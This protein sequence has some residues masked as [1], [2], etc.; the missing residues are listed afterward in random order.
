MHDSRVV[1][2][3][4]LTLQ[5]SNGDWLLVKKR[6]NAGE[7]R[8]MIKRGSVQTDDGLRVDSIEAGLAKILAFLLDWSLKGPDGQVLP[9]RGAHA[10][11]LD[12]ALDSIDPE[13]YTEIL[14]A[15]EAHEL[16][17]QAERAAQKKIPDSPATSLPPSPSPAP[18]DSPT[19]G[20]SS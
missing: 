4:S 13:S 2:P 9:I 5:I 7:N 16:A 15:I 8:K 18:A 17:M 14:R 12:A 1:S 19:S 10:M 3:D 11:P 20:L 6:L